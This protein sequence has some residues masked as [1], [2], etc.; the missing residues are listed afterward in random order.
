MIHLIEDILKTYQ[1][2]GF[3]EV[4]VELSTRPKKSIGTSEMWQKAETALEQALQKSN[5]QFKLN[6]GD[7]AFYGPKIDFHIKDSLNRK[8][9]CGTIQLDFSMPERF[10]VDYVA[11]D[12]TK[13]RV[14]MIHRAILGSP[15]RFMGI[16][17]EHL[18]G[19]FPTWLAPVQVIILNVT[20]NQKAYAESIYKTLSENKIRVEID[21]RNE[22]L[23][24]KIRQAQLQKIPYMIVIG[25]KE[26]S[27]QTIS[28]RTRDGENL[29]PMKLEPFIER[30][31]HET[32]QKIA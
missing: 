19:K 5:L 3:K 14:V 2:F 30:I 7:G 8:W 22:K 24:Y 18:A 4:Q 1:D 23:G 29:K 9:Q 13:H 32:I 28:V 27:E 10:D 20:D 6:P 15:E 31:K 26:V 12:G 11:Q 17:I 21:I 25:D 16:L